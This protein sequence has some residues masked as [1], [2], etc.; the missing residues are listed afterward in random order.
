MRITPAEWLPREVFDADELGEGF[1]N[2]SYQL[3]AR[4]EADSGTWLS[5]LLAARLDDGTRVWLCGV[6]GACKNVLLL[7]GRSLSADL[8][9]ADALDS[10]AML[11]DPADVSNESMAAA[12]A[13]VRLGSILL[14]LS[15]HNPAVVLSRLVALVDHER[16]VLVLKLI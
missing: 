8:D 1:I 13:Q 9:S 6:T 12:H 10:Q 3:R 7:N 2:G 11:D 14:D 15:N 5:F 4:G 16:L